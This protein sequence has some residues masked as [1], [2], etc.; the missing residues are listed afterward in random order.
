[1][2][3]CLDLGINIVVTIVISLGL[4]VTCGG[5]VVVAY[6][7]T[8][9]TPNLFYPMGIF[10]ALY[11]LIEM[12]EGYIHLVALAGKAKKKGFWTGRKMMILSYLLVVGLTIY[13]L[14]ALY[15]SYTYYE[16]L[17][18]ASDNANPT[19]YSEIESK[20]AKYFN[21]MFFQASYL[22]NGKYASCLILLLVLV[23]INCCACLVAN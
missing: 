12:V 17:Q 15:T 19:K 3:K 2:L 22:C 7:R 16:D 21:Q 6:L 10:V 18:K 13:D 20:L 9:V 4:L 8:D 11:G 14:Y 1:M 23:L 5:I